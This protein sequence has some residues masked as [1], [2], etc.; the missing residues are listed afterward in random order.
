MIFSVFPPGAGLLHYMAGHLFLAAVASSI[1]SL[2]FMFSCFNMKPAAATI[3]AMSFMLLNLVVENLSF[4]ED[5]RELVLTHHV[6]SWLLVF[7]Q[8]MQTARMAQ[9]LSVLVAFS[10][11]AFIIG[12]TNFQMRDIK[13]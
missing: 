11:I 2:A 5:Y 10:L 1:F 8:P 6:K 13:S 4:F 7:A 12:A 3:A 9:S